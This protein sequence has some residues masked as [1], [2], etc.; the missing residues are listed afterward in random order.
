ML[1]MLLKEAGV[2]AQLV[3]RWGREGDSAPS[4]TL[5]FVMPSE[6]NHKNTFRGRI[7]CD[8]GDFLLFGL[9]VLPP[10]S[11]EDI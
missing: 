7:F 3:R 8:L 10:T 2:S 4:L 6:F 11:T 9:F 5:Y 1:E